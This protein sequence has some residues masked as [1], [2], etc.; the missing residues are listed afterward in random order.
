VSRAFLLTLAFLGATVPRPVAAGGFTI[1]VMGGRR[2]SSLVN[3]ARPD[4]PTAV[5]HNPAGLADQKGV[6][7]QAS[8]AFY[9]VNTE[10][11]MKQ[12]DPT[13]YPE[14]NPAGCGVGQNDPCPW[15][16]NSDGFYDRTI[17]PESYFGTIPYLGATTDLGF[18]GADNV[19]AGLAL[20]LP[21]FYGATMPSDAPTRYHMLDGSFAVGSVTAGA[22]WRV[23][24]WLAV[25][26]SLSY[27][28]MRIT[29]KRKLSIIAALT[30]AGQQPSGNAVLG[31]NGIGDITMDY[32]GV[33]HG[34]GWGASVLLTPPP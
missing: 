11:R 29:I 28:Y 27:N 17:E 2:S 19:V 21:A 12:L 34:V 25:G 24:R 1:S 26:A 23:T 7:L 16:V 4:D 13:F 9:F 3:L 33:D 22:G 31:Q 8:N 18:L 30:P 14:V 32:T 6:Q 15:P 5:F 10:F 20:Y